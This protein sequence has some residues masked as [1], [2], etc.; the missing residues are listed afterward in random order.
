MKRRQV[1]RASHG[2]T[3]VE[4]L[5]VVV[6]V[7]VLLAGLLLPWFAQSNHQRRRSYCVNN[8]KQA[9]LAARIFATDNEDQFPWRVSTNSGGS[10]EFVDTPFSA[11]RHFLVMSNELSTPR[12]VACPE[13]RR[14][15][16]ATNWSGLGNGNV[17]YFVGLEAV[18]H[19]PMSILFGDRYLLTPIQPAN[20]FLRLHTNDVVGWTKDFHQSEGNLAFGDGSVAHLTSARL[21][22]K[23]RHSGSTTNRWVIP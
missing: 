13:D 9:G 5:V 4:V 6:A 18:E 16:S 21:Q 8:L 11:F 15:A 1:N 10:R 2:L 17:S 22:E 7:V 23:L 14:R 19:H 3:L 20:G 12:V